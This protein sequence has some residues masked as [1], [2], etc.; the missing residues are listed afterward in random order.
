VLH[1][2]ITFLRDEPGGHD[3]SEVEGRS[4]TRSRTFQLL[5]CLIFSLSLTALA[6]LDSRLV[7]KWVSSSGAIIEIGYPNE[8]TTIVVTL[9]INGG[10]PIRATLEGGDM[11]SII[12]KYRSSNGSMMEG[13]YDPQSKEI[14][15]Y[16]KDKHYSTWTRK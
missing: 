12:M 14:S 9:S 3:P 7:G 2:P 13:Y 6:Q 16:E 5:V 8:D 15:V 11:D 10:Q 4:M 1:F